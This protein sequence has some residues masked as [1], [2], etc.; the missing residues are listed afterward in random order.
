MPLS[1]TEL[2]LFDGK[3]SCSESSNDGHDATCCGCIERKHFT[4][5]PFCTQKGSESFFERIDPESRTLSMFEM[6]DGNG[7]ILVLGAITNKE[8]DACS[9]V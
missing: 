8:W 5:G 1:W 3:Q 2:F 9:P 7:A 6:V 4:T